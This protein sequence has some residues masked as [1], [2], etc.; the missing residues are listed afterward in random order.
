MDDLRTPALTLIPRAGDIRLW[1]HTTSSRKPPT[2]G[3]AGRLENSFYLRLDAKGPLFFRARR[4][5]FAKI[6]S[7]F[8]QRPHPVNYGNYK[9]RRRTQMTDEILQMVEQQRLV[10]DTP[11]SLEIYW[12]IQRKIKTAKAK[13]MQEDC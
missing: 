12:Q 8:D 3:G 5:W 11:K 10:E 7:L 4:R 13:N 1:G 6:S 9:G 2:V